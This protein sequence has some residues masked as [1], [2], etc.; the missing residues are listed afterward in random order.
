MELGLEQTS[1]KKQELSILRE[2]DLVTFTMHSG[3]WQQCVCY[4]T[5]CQCVALDDPSIDDDVK[6][7]L[8]GFSGKPG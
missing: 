7:V 3:L 5:L 8:H 2:G 4:Q 1:G 6:E